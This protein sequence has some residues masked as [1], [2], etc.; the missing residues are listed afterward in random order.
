MNVLV[1]GANGFVGQHVIRELQAANHSPVALVEPGQSSTVTIP[2]VEANIVD[3]DQ[4]AKIVH[5]TRPEACIHLAGMAFVP[6]AWEHPQ[7]AFEVNV[8]GVLN[9]IQAIRTHQ[10]TCRTLIV[11]SSEVYGREARTYPLSENEPLQPSNMYGTTK[12]SADQSALLMAQKFNLPIMTARP[13][14]HIGP[15]QSPNFVV[16]AF[17]QQLARMARGQSELLMRTG[18]LESERE[19]T[20]VRDVARAYRLLIEK[21]TNGKAYNVGAGVV[22]TIQSVLDELLT[23]AQV[24]PRIETDQK[25]WRPTDKSLVLDTAQ[26]RGD[27]GWAPEIPIHQTLKNIYQWALAQSADE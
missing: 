25:L 10:P 17:A 12:A 4:V 6:A 18:N 3:K 9:L 11:T 24:T 7:Q 16:M 13:N 23:C 14:N 15:G 27:T 26:L 8:I 1:T 21:G 2:S 19:F 22:L 5:S 20:D